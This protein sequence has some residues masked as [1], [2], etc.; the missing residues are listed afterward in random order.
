MIDLSTLSVPAP[1]PTELSAPFWEAVARR[2]FVLQHCTRCGRWVFYPRQICPHCWSADLV[3]EPASGLGRLATWSVI[4][5]AGHPGWQPAT[6]YVVGIVRLV[7]GPSM[8][9]LILAAESGLG[10]DFPVRV[11]FT[12]VGGRLLPCFEPAP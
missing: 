5:R 6:P 1:T 2:S 7:E 11:A 3:W 10:R 4:H 12:D 9:S 8:L